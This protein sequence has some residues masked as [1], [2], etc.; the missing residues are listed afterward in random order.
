MLK[1]W[2]RDP[3]AAKEPDPGHPLSTAPHPTT[4]RPDSDRIMKFTRPTTLCRWATHPQLMRTIATCAHPV[5]PRG[6]RL[7]VLLAAVTAASLAPATAQAAPAAPEE[8]EEACKQARSLAEFLLSTPDPNRRCPSRFAGQQT[9]E[10]TG[11]VNGHRVRRAFSRHDSCAIADWDRMG[12]LLNPAISPSRAARPTDRL[13]AA[14]T[15][16]APNRPR[17]Q[18]YPGGAEIGHP[19]PLSRALVAVD[20]WSAATSP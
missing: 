1:S 14:T 9:A 18:E 11:F 12:L 15:T 13:S 16:R 6:R 5:R 10:V 7:A 17:V 8:P 4:T 20:V 19:G 2:L 3:H